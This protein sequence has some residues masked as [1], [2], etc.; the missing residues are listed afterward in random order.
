MRLKTL[1][2]TVALVFVS[3]GSAAA[4][5]ETGRIAGMVVDEQGGAVPGVNVTATSVATG[6]SRSTVTDGTGNYVLANLL[7]A[8][9][10]VSFRI[11]GFRT[12]TM[13]VQLTVGAEVAADAT[14]A[15]GGITE[16]VAIT[17]TAERVNVRTAEIATTISQ[18]QITE[19]P[20]LTRDP[21]D[22]ISIT[23]NVSDQDPTGVGETEGRGARGF[24]ING[25]RSTATNVLLDGAANNDEFTGAVGQSV[26]LDSVQEFSVISSNFSAQYGRATAG[27]VNVATKAGSNE[28]RGSAYEFFRNQKLSTRTIDQE[29]RDIEKSPFDRHQAGFSIGGPI[30]KNRAHFFANVEYIRVRSTSTEIALVPTPEFLARTA[31]ATQNFFSKYALAAPIAGPFVTRG[32][33]G[34]TPGGPFAGLPASLPV[35]GQVQRKIPTNAGGGSPQDTLQLVG[36]VDWTMGDNMN[37]YVRYALENQEFLVGSNAN[38]PYQGFDAGAT[39]DNHN[40]LF[41]L[42]RVWSPRLTTQSKIVFNRLKN[43]QPLGDQPDGPTLYARS[44]TTRISGVRIAFPGYLPFQ[45]GSAI[46]FGGPQNL[47]QTY[48]DGNWFGGKHDLRFGGSYVR[49]MDNRT[50]GAY[51]N[52]VQTLGASLAAAMD[53][54]MLGQ[55]LSFAGAI[56]PQGK[57]PGEIVTLPARQP[58]FTRNNRYNEFALYFNDAWAFQPNVTVNLGAR[59]EYY[60]VQHNKDPRLDSN[61]YY[62]PGNQFERIRSGRAMITPDSP[63]KDLWAKDWNNIAPRVGIAWDVRGDGR[64][65]LRGGYGI[66]YERNFGNVTFNVIQNPPNYAVVSLVAGVDVPQI[67][68]T[69]DNAGPLSG[70]GTKTLPRTSLR[71]VD[72]DIENAYAHFWSASFQQQLGGNTV[73]AIDYSGSRGEKLYTIEDPNKPGYGNVYLGDTA[74]LS[75]LNAQYSNLNTRANKGISRYQSVTFAVENRGLGETGLSFTSRYTFGRAK[76]NLSSTF[77]ESNNNFNL[78]LLDPFNPRLDFGFADFDVRH[79]FAAS[80]IWQIPGGD[81]GSTAMRQLVGGWQLNA[82]F[83]AQTGAPFTIFDCTNALT[84]CMRMLG[85][86]SIDRNGRSDPPSTGDP[87]TFAYMDISSQLPAAGSYVH[88]KTDTNDVGPWPSNMTERNFFRRPGKWN[89]DLVVAKRFRF[90]GRSALQVRIEMYNVFKHGNLYIDDASADISAGSSITAFRGDRGDNDGV[91]EGDG[92]RRAQIGVRF[93]F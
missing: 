6:A 46:P 71:H 3:L 24:A 92:Q 27:I 40:A 73:A 14:L 31:P 67:P 53:N 84:V 45:P 23:G 69:T 8:S 22:L 49:I 77:S 5:T 51:Q 30:R 88:P 41:A 7:P 2:A 80:A 81:A 44:T 86:G 47:I 35:F 1:A 79:R 68:I 56:D 11:Q 54:L 42:T 66:G 29:E 55:L 64:T 75:R 28:F 37:A 25:L 93:E 17:A 4:Q 76:D 52:S 82:I 61:F 70:T 58:N 13:R 38:S 15:V 19:L 63:V 10:E 85:V 20:T 26:P 34:G 60:G 57:F 12:T 78:G 33:I 18:Q 87:N 90:A 83:V 72:Q 50:F 16:T 32:E 43:L 91:P 62:G 48:H 74:P 89:A 36:R 9:Y 59:Y 65:S 21:Y 39:E